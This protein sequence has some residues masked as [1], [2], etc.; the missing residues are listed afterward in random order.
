MLH[1]GMQVCKY[2][3]MEGAP[4]DNIAAP[5]GEHADVHRANRPGHGGAV[6]SLAPI[7]R[8][9]N[10][11][12]TSDR[13]LDELTNEIRTLR[14]RPGQVLSESEL[15][16]QLGVSR[17]P[18]REALA[19]LVDMGLV[20]VVPQVGTRVELIR[21]SE[22]EQARFMREHLEVAAF[23]SAAQLPEVNTS[24]ARRFLDEQRAAAASGDLGRFFAADEMMHE[25]IFVM[26]GYGGVWQ[27][28][29]R[30]KLQLDRLRMLSETDPATLA[31][32]LDDHER[33]IAALEARDLTAGRWHVRTHARRAIE[34]TPVLREK[35]PHYFA[36]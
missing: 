25:Q 2:T 3:H 10:Q 35:Y 12:R 1:A 11:R 9:G 4:P 26:C 27:A 6:V 28:V 29:R 5:A 33:V 31:E 22:V 13:V 21:L 34:K 30:V 14:L 24:L 15:A 8:L 20:M 19:R 7:D 23:E 17:T 18:V 32:L 36:D 16:R